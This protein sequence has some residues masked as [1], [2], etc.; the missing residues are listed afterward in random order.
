MLL[1][2]GL[3]RL[4]GEGREIIDDRKSHAIT[5]LEIDLKRGEKKGEGEEED[6]NRAL[7]K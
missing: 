4:L 5:G 2:E 3:E 7:G 1:G 6:R